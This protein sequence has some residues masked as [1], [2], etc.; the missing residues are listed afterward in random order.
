MKIEKNIELANNI[1]RKL[2]FILINSI[3]INSIT[4]RVKA[5][6]NDDVTLVSCYIKTDIRR[7]D[8][9]YYMLQLKNLLILNKSL[10]FFTE[11]PLKKYLESFV[12]KK[13]QIKSY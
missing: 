1:F 2:C 10:V 3:I 9:L 12:G 8:V 6:K 13:M 5:Y 7:H 11:P 4:D